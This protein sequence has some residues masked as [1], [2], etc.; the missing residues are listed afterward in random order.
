[1]NF[2]DIFLRNFKFDISPWESMLGDREVIIGIPS[3]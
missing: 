1:M 3:L 2:F